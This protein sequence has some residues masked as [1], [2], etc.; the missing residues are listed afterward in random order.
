MGGMAGAAPPLGTALRRALWFLG[1]GWAV[2]A[3]LVLPQAR[4]RMA[5]LM[6]EGVRPPLSAALPSSPLEWTVLAAALLLLAVGFWILTPALLRADPDRMRGGAGTSAGAGADARVLTWSLAGIAALLSLA[7]LSPGEPTILDAKSHVGRAWLWA[8]S[9]RQFSIP[10]WTDLWYGGFPGDLHYPPLSHI[11]AALPILVGMDSYE[12]VKVVAWL[13]LIAAA[14]GFGLLARTLHDSAAAGMVGGLIGVL[15]PPF[16]NAW[17]WEGRLP[18][19]L[20]IGILPWLFLTVERLIRGRTGLRGAI[21]LGLGIWLLALAHLG[22]ARAALLLLGLFTALRLGAAWR[23]EG[24]RERAL[25]VMAGWLCGIVLIA[26]FV[27]PLI[28]EKSW[29][30]YLA[31]PD[32]MKLTA[33]VF[34]DLTRLFGFNP[35]GQ[36]ILGVSLLVL[37]IVGVVRAVRRTRGETRDETRG[38]TREVGAIG[39]VAMGAL[40]LAPWFFCSTWGRGV[41][42]LF[43]GGILA[44]PAAVAFVRA[45]GFGLAVLLLLCDLGPTQLFSTY[46]ASDQRKDRNRAYSILEAGAENG[47]MLELPATADGKI[48]PISWTFAPGRAVPSLG[49]PFIQG[50][51]LDFRHAAPVIDTLA[52]AMNAQAEID[53]GLVRLLAFHGVESIIVVGPTELSPPN[54]RGAGLIFDAALPGLRVRD[55][56]LVFSLSAGGPAPPPLP[57]RPLSSAGYPASLSREL[58]RGQLEWLRAAAP[59]PIHGVTARVLPNQMRLSVVGAPGGEVRIAR[60]AYPGTRVWIDGVDTA[61][62]PAPLGGIRIALPAG[63]HEVRIE[64]PISRLRRGCEIAQTLLVG[65]AVVVWMRARSGRVARGRG[66]A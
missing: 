12:A 22:Q 30:N 21:E 14:V 24:I 29:V 49:G 23:V 66:R 39:P 20:L 11:L 47:R 1:P 5:G 27:L 62:R 37:A 34:A 15:A 13:S 58:A 33:P 63:D 50:A 45:P 35:R 41:D 52:Q 36:G 46:S 6:R 44:A 60:A 57:E 31:A 32:R 16:H 9:L 3:L 51:P 38:E 4:D 42:L 55:A 2:L 56:S 8:E 43:L 7:L 65:L 53:S 19:L 10:R 25:F 48:R 40:I 17:L 18:G 28:D 61:W 64:T 54:A 59:T 26:P